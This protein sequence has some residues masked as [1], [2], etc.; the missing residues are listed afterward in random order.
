MLAIAS[1]GAGALAFNAVR[2]PRWARTR[3]RQMQGIAERTLALL[4]PAPSSAATEVR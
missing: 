4:G 1:M 3:E 2:L